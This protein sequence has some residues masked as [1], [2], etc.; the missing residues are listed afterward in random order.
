MHTGPLSEHVHAGHAVAG[1]VAV[2]VELRRGLTGA[3]GTVVMRISNVARSVVLV[4]D[5]LMHRFNAQDMR[6]L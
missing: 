3:P 2:L 4:S 5:A 1:R 6:S